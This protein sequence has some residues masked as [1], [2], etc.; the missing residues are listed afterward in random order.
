M[1]V[2]RRLF[3]VVGPAFKAAGRVPSILTAGR[4]RVWNFYSPAF[5]SALAVYL[6]RPS[7]LAVYLF[8]PSRPQ[9]YHRFRQ[10]R[11]RK[12]AAAMSNWLRSNV[13]C[14][15]LHRLVTAGQ[16]PPLTNVVE[17]KVP[18]EES[19][20]RPP[21]G[22]SSR[23]WPSKSMASPLPPGGSSVEYGLQLQH[24]NPKSV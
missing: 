24:L 5:S 20:S 16:L 13:S 12:L 19:V 23:S 8:C 18:G 7:A 2:G 1:R 15:M 22:T 9:R 10:S 14:M 21:K 4:R 3:V 6:F 11:T 17:W